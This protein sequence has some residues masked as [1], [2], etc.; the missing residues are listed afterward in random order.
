MT[1]STST[2][3]NTGTPSRRCGRPP[4]RTLEIVGIVVAF[5]W[6]WPVALAYVVWKMLGYPK[7]DQLRG[8]FQDA[9]GRFEQAFKGSGRGFGGGGFGG[10]FGPG[11]TGNAAFDE[12][13]RKE[14][15][16]LEAERRKLDEEARA[17]SDFVEELKRAK[18]RE[19]FDA[20]MAK[21]R[22]DQTG[23]ATDASI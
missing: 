2:A 18:D 20:F 1:F 23:P 10:G 17:F 9:F 14:I 12:Y 11:S 4:R 7:S 6:F 16:R 21:R 15:E 13:R 19:E 5:V 3:W 22:A 8:Y